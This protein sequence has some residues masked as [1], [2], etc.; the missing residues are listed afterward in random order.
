MTSYELSINLKRDGVPVSGYPIVRRIEATEAQEFSYAKAND[1]D[2]T[3]FSAIPANEIA[4]VKFLIVRTDKSVTVRLDGQTD[5]GITL[6]AGGLLA[7]IDATID[8][9]AGASN[10]KVNN[11]SGAVALIEGIAGGL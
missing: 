8:A 7:I 3:T 2:L 4:T 1:G 10:A 11:N 9:G 5:A 6:D